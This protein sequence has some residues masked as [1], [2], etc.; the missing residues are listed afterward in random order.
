MLLSAVVPVRLP[1]PFLVET[2]ESLENQTV[3]VDEIVLVAHGCA[4]E[5][6]Q[7]ALGFGRVRVVSA[8]PHLDLTAVRR[9]GMQVARGDFIMLLDADDVALPRR[10]E[11]QIRLMGNQPQASLCASP[12]E[13]IDDAGRSL[14]SRYVREQHGDIRRELLLRNRIAQSSVLLRRSAYLA[15]GGYK[16]VALAEDY[17]L[18]L[19]MA[20]LGPIAWSDEALVK[21]RVHS[22]QLTQGRTVP[23]AGWRAIWLA[24]AS[25]GSMLREPRSTTFF[26]HVVWCVAQS[27]RRRPTSV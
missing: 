19:R 24:R 11:I 10:A 9:L 17:E 22:G 3:V 8:D 5:M 12:V 13:L 20:A 27:R 23:A 21:Y 7:I 14:G 4:E 18:W 16:S 1:A 6:A 26:K 25:L 15:V 2:L